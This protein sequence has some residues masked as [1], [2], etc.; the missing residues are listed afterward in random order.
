MQGL[1]AFIIS[2]LVYAQGPSISAVCRKKKF[3]AEG[4]KK[5]K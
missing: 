2:N 5:Q 1:S 4:L 3:K